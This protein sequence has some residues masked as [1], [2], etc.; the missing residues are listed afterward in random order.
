V[1]EEMLSRDGYRKI[2]VK[3]A[4]KDQLRADRL[5]AQGRELDAAALLCY[6][7]ITQGLMAFAYLEAEKTNKAN[8]VQ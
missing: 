6:S 5:I 4:H 8:K 7:S 2:A 3:Y 1:N